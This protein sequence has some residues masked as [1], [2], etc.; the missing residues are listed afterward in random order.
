ML[1]DQAYLIDLFRRLAW[2]KI[3]AHLKEFS[4]WNTD[5][6]HGYFRRQ[7]CRDLIKYHVPDALVPLLRRLRSKTV[8]DTPD[9][10]WYTEEFRDRIRQCASGQT[11]VRGPFATAHARS[12][13]Q[14][15][16]S[17]HHVQCINWNNNV[18]A[19]HGIEIAFPF[20]DRDLISFLMGIPGEVQ[21]WK[22]VPKAIL[23]EATRGVLPD[24]IVARTWKGD[25]T[26]VVN[27]AMS[28]EYPRLV[29][30]LEEGGMAIGLGYVK[31]EVMREELARLRDGIRGPDCGITWSLSDLLGLELW[32]QVFFGDKT[33][34][35][36][37]VP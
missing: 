35:T 26:H 28:R 16:R 20:L 33:A 21:A 25:F 11:L 6:N 14:E 23:R 12:L 19:M 2:G 1:F 13:Y 31:G 29:H 10:P 34:Y 17:R 30:C 18:A 36:S 4:R 9:R 22:G 27:E 3:W 8:R 24:A 15:A 7:F 37:V 32:L 5:V